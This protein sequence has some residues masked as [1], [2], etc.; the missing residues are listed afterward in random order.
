LSWTCRY[1]GKDTSNIDYDYLDGY[2]HLSCALENF[3]KKKVMKIKG[4]EKISGY[5]YKGFSIVN[6]IHNAEETSYEATVLNL[7]LPQNPKWELNVLTPKH[8]FKQ[9]NDFSIILRD[10]EN[11]STIHTIDKVCM[12]SI[13]I[14]RQTFEEMIDKM[15]GMRLTTAGVTANSHSFNINVN[16][17]QRMRINSNGHAIVGNYSKSINP[18]LY[19][20]ALVTGTGGGIV[21]KVNN[22]G[23][24]SIYDSST[25]ISIDVI[26]TI[27]TLQKQIDELKLNTPS[28]PF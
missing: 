9:D 17:N 15:L 14:F 26:D 2:D 20:T 23:T 11:R 25:G 6:P 19:G 24:I 28:T 27:K 18:N 13:S 4:W 10:D 22:S 21:N 1:C 5:T 7:N 16:G 12:A 3:N 8:K